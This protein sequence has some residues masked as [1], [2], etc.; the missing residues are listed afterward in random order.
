MNARDLSNRLAD[1]LRKERHALAEFLLA[2]A[3]FDRDRAWI[4]LGYKSL[5]DYLHRDLRLSK[6]AAFYRMTAARLVQRHPEIVEPLRDG[7]LCLTTVVALSKV[8]T[9]ENV[10]EVL[11]RFFQ[12]SKREAKEVAAELS[13]TP[14]PVRTVVTEVR[15]PALPSALA[16]SASAAAPAAQ[17]APESVAPLIPVSWPDEPNR[18][19]PTP[20]AVEPK[21]AEQ[22]R[23]HL[24]VS[25]EFLRKLEAARDALSHSHPGAGEDEILEAG[26]DLLLER[27]AKRRGLV[28]NPRKVPPRSNEAACAPGHARDERSNRYVPAHVRRA[29]WKRDAG[30]CQW[31]LDGGGVCGSTVRVE[32]DHL[33]LRARGG[34]SDDPEKLRL[35]C[36]FHNDLAARKAFGDAWI[37]QVHGR[38]QSEGGRRGLRRSGETKGACSGERLLVTLVPS[39]QPQRQLREEWCSITLRASD[40]RSRTWQERRSKAQS[41]RGTPWHRGSSSPTST[42]GSAM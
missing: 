17:T 16:L 26:L 6:G 21:T 41:S 18:A 24:T 9:S 11:S 33:I 12:A 22:S 30:R 7:R 3:E 19:P 15:A 4:R 8:L 34:P 36:R 1:L 10:S 2:L 14:A 25:R 32:I 35:L 40:R 20:L 39:L 42:Q 31:P 38:T 13:P 5:F 28:K 37:G 23:I 29:V 27:H